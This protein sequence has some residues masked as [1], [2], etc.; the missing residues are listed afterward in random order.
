MEETE[1]Q[2]PVVWLP[3]VLPPRTRERDIPHFARHGAEPPKHAVFEHLLALWIERFKGP[4]ETRVATGGALKRLSEWLDV[5]PQN[6]SGWRDT[7]ERN[8][9]RRNGAPWWACLAIADYLD[10][11]I[12]LTA[13]GDGYMIIKKPKTSASKT[14]P[15]PVPA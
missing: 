13:D 9:R 11:A 4:T 7:T 3:P 6:I 15:P 10:V 5:I 1:P 12:L 14:K 8:G 2:K